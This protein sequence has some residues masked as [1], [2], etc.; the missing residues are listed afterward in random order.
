[1]ADVQNKE[2]A[3]LTIYFVWSRCRGI[4]KG[5]V[6]ST[7]KLYNEVKRVDGFCYLGDR[8]N[9]SGGCKATVTAKI[10]IGWERFRKCGKLLLENMFPLRMKDEVYCCCVNQQCCRKK[11]IIRRTKRDM[12]KAVCGQK[13][14]ESST[15]EEQIVMLEL[16]KTMNGLTTANRVRWYGHLLTKDEDSVLRVALDFEVSGKRKQG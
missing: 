6:N 9:A 13:V 11:A 14:V 7:E 8:L 5:I 12:M 1:M 15:T 4:I 16:K 3:R 2:S 10:K